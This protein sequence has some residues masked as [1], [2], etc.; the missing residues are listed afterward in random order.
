MV[1]RMM[2]QEDEDHYTLA[3]PVLAQASAGMQA[4]SKPSTGRTAS[5]RTLTEPEQKRKASQWIC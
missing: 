3:K 5:S 4:S 2:I 1:K